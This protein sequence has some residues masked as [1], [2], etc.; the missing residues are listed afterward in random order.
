VIDTLC[1]QPRRNGVVVLFFYC[2][3]RTKK[4]QSAV[5]IIGCLLRQFVLGAA[6]IP[7]GIRK[8]FDE[9]GQGNRKGLPLP[10]MVKLF[11]KTIIPLERAYICIDAVDELLP[12]ERAKFLDALGQISRQAPNMRVFLTAMPKVRGEIEKHFVDGAYSKIVEID[13]GDIARDISRKMDDSVGDGDVLADGP[14]NDTMRRK[15]KKA[16]DM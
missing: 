8:A 11:I 9:S 14:I 13:Q 1:E 15:S 7:E 2:D 6:G 3:Y 4:A 10:E 12:E 5:N 16:S